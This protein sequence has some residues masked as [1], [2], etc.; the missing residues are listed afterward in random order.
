M[1]EVAMFRGLG[2]LGNNASCRAGHLTIFL[3]ASD[4][5]CSLMCQGRQ[6]AMSG[7]DAFGCLR[8]LRAHRHLMG[9]AGL[10]RLG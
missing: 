5:L 3:S 7:S 9:S 1:R 10:A 2:V 8:S 6:L 4:R